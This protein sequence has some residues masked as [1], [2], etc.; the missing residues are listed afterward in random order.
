LTEFKDLEVRFVEIVGH[1]E[2]V[3]FYKN[4]LFVFVVYLIYSR[5][6]ILLEID[7]GFQ[8]LAEREKYIKSR[9]KDKKNT[10]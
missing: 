9:E 4:I 6:N 10:I 2:N 1:L 5:F 8:K 7:K 3:T